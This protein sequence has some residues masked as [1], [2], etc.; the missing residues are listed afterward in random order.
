MF[1]VNTP[2]RSDLGPVVVV[3]AERCRGRTCVALI[4][5]G[6]MFRNGYIWGLTRMSYRTGGVDGSFSGKCKK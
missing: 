6:E 3:R 4:G 5:C 1:G 2:L